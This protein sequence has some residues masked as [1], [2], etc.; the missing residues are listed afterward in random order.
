M[1]HHVFVIPLSINNTMATLFDL[2]SQHNPCICDDITAEIS[3]APIKGRPVGDV[4][5]VLSLSCVDE[6]S[7]FRGWFQSCIQARLRQ[8]RDSEVFTRYCAIVGKDL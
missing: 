4:Y 2:A 3:Y 5:P 1:H 6:N 7:L 8:R